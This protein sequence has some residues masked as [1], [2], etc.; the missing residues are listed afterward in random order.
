L[1]SKNKYKLW[2]IVGSLSIIVVLSLYNYI[3]NK[4]IFNRNLILTAD[5][6]AVSTLRPGSYVYYAGI[7]VGKVQ[8]IRLNLD[9]NHIL[10]EFDVMP[11]V[12]LPENTY[13]VA[14]TPSVL[15][16]ARLDLRFD[17]NYSGIFLKSGA[18]IQG[19]VGSYLLDVKKQ[20]EPYV[21]KIDTIILSQFPNKQNLKQVVADIELSITNFYRSSN[22]L[23]LTLDSNKNNINKQVIS[24][25][26]SLAGIH[27]MDQKINQTIQDL[28]I[29]TEKFKSYDYSHKKIASKLD[30][31]NLPDLSKST[32]HI[33]EIEN[34][35]AKINSRQDTVIAKYLYDYDYKL[36]ISKNIKD[37]GD[38]S[39][40]IRMNPQN[41]ISLRKKKTV[42][43]TLTK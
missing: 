16:P 33:T 28:K 38:Q 15:Y 5:F 26:K 42:N 11:G 9:N 17:N 23:R 35:L 4:P 3:R 7:Q 40:E 36:K 41:T 25:N 22:N 24:L 13:A 34:K 8:D 12:Y 19:E 37:I 6:E 14:Y 39:R 32:K 31:I 43:K 20:V 2:G 29:S 18:L 27:S 21:K 1:H 30:S 10:V